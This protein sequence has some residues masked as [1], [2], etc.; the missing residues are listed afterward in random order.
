MTLTIETKTQAGLY[1]V[2]QLL[3]L[4]MRN[5]LNCAISD[6]ELQ[7]ITKITALVGGLGLVEHLIKVLFELLVPF[8]ELLYEHYTETHAQHVL[9]WI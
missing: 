8:H 7:K 2:L 4:V 9:P 6:M 1:W 3:S 5:E